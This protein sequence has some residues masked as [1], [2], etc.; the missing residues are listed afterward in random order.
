MVGWW[1]QGTE[2]T[3]EKW[4][5]QN[6]HQNPGLFFSNT[7]LFPLDGSHCKHYER[8]KNAI[9]FPVTDGNYYESSRFCFTAAV[10]PGYLK[11]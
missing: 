5:C 10:S 3:V 2:P 9:Y 4:F 6:L 1:K 8:V 11:C 7:A